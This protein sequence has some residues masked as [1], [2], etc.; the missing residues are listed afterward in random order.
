MASANLRR[1]TSKSTNGRHGEYQ[2]LPLF[3]ALHIR[4][5]R[6]S[7]VLGRG[8]RVDDGGICQCARAQR[9]PLFGEMRVQLSKDRLCQRAALHKVAK[10]EDRGLVEDAI[11]ARL[12]TGKPAHRLAEPVG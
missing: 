4:V 1:S 3:F 9:H 12:D 7:L 10:V 2:A 6:A 5:A 8:R 11:I